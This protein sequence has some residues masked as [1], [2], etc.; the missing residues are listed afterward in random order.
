MMQVHSIDS[1]FH[2]LSFFSENFRSCGNRVSQFV[3]DCRVASD[4]AG[5]S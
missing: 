5:S 4:G 1:S 3:R 2:N